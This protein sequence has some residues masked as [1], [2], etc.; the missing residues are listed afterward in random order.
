MAR[1]TGSKEIFSDGHGPSM[2]RG[3]IGMKSM[4]RFRMASLVMGLVA[5]IAG[6][7]LTLPQV[8]QASGLGGAAAQPL[9][10]NSV[11]GAATTGA[12]QSR[13]DKKQFKD[14]KVTVDNGVAV[15]TGTVD[16]YEDKADAQKRVLHAKGVTAVRNEIQVTGP[17]VPDQ[18]LKTK[19]SQ[20]LTYDPDAYGKLFDAIGVDV[21]NGVVT[22][23]GHAH[24]YVDRDSAVAIVSTTPGVKDVVDNI[25]VDPVSQMDDRIRLDVA[26][27]VYG[28][29]SLNR[30]A[31]DPAKPIRIAVQNGNVELYGVVDSQAD[32]NAANIQANSVAGVFSVKNYI[33]V[34]N[35]PGESQK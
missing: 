28:F 21:N 26:R 5:G 34:A 6:A 27:A 16:M 13:L 9:Q 33:Q 31:I 4:I 35:Q 23:G 17:S 8:S 24:N 20:K 25:E 7:L 11:T 14:V 30:Y 3:E 15:L 22:L 12:A 18:E 29:P 2:E 19:L 32:K 1:V 10:D